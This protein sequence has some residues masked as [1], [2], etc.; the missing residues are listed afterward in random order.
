MDIDIPPVSIDMAND[1]LYELF[2]YLP[3]PL[4]TP[5]FGWL[6]FKEISRADRKSQLK[7]VW[8]FVQ[9]IFGPHWPMNQLNKDPNIAFPSG[10]EIRFG[11]A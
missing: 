10:L 1:V 2:P 11:S 4:F 5:L 9:L 8:V 3:L 6:C 7:T